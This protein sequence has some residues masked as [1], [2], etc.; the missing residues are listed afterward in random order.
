[1]IELA[2]ALAGQHVQH[3]LVMA[4][5]SGSA[6]GAGARRLAQT[7]PG[8]I[9]AVIAL[10][11]LAAAHPH[12]AAVV[13][14]SIGPQVAPPA[15]RNTVASALTAQAGVP[16]GNFGI[17]GQLGRLAVPMTL[18]EQA[19][20]GARGIP[21]VT[22]SLISDAR[23]TPGE[24]LS[25]DQLTATGR[26]VL[27][28][29]NALDSGPRMPTAKPYLVLSGKVI[30]VWAA[31]LL[32]LALLVPVM[33]VAVDGLARARRRG[34]SVSSG[35]LRAFSGAV[36]FL[37]AG[38]FAVL[39][40]VLGWVDAPPGPV[41]SGEFPLQGAGVGLVVVVGLVLV[42][43]M[44]LWAWLQF[45]RR[46][47]QGPDP[48][49]AVGTLLLLVLVTFALGI[50]NPF[51]AILA[52]PAVHLWMW[53]LDGELRPHPALAVALIVLGLVAPVL[54]LLDYAH[55]LGLGIGELPWNSLL[56]IAGGAIGPVLVAL[57]CV[58]AGC[59]LGVVTLATQKVFSPSPEDGPVTVRGPVTYA[60]PGSLGGTESAL[61]VRR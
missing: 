6:G 30:P 20:F 40:R 9:D 59:T 49:Q 39:A 50:V 60:G 52:V 56:L 53:L 13:P 12:G 34:Y 33:L 58:L 35:I 21:A 43:G 47:A 8:P 25:P 2:R 15:L 45:R 16:A 24:P 11:D 29:V 37:L 36:P 26:A 10:G 31:Q 54:I 22:L 5:V 23:S 46:G 3:T 27:V 1:M 61:R 57:W 14:W 7:L 55:A 17:A 4:S 28:A 51:D 44:P 48:A 38:A 18:G 42:I 19:P 32:V 41:G